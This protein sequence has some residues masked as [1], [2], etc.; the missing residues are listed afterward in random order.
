MTENRTY[1]SFFLKSAARHLRILAAVA[2]VA[3]AANASCTEAAAQVASVHHRRRCFLLHAALP[4]L[5]RDTRNCTRVRLVSEKHNVGRSLFPASLSVSLSLFR[6]RHAPYESALPMQLERFCLLRCHISTSTRS[7]ELARD[8]T[9]P[10]HCTNS[11]R[12]TSQRSRHCCAQP[13]RCRSFKKLLTTNIKYSTLYRADRL[14]SLSE[15]RSSHGRVGKL[16]APVAASVRRRSRQQVSICAQSGGA[17][18]DAAAVQGVLAGAAAG[19]RRAAR[20][21][22]STTV[23]S[24]EVRWNYH[25]SLHYMSDYFTN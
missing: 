13:Q 11:L 15:C 22:Y 25:F 9:R 20:W 21:T 17:H 6:R 14:P 16:A 12:P 8:A 10:H 24:E 1:I 4:L 19:V 23:A 3:L 7:S 18:G 5:H 2:A